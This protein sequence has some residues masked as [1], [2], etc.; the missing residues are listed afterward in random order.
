MQIANKVIWPLMN[1]LVQD[2]FQTVSIRNGPKFSDTHALANSADPDQTALREAVWSW[3]TL[4][5]I[6]STPFGHISLRKDVYV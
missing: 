1:F 5:A 3:S 4:F 2:F 6:L